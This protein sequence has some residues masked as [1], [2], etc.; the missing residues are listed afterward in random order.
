MRTA[1]ELLEKLGERQVQARDR[2]RTERHARVL[3]RLHGSIERDAPA[4]RGWIAGGAV[5][6]CAA[7]ALALWLSW[8]SPL[9]FEVEARNQ[10]SASSSVVVAEDEPLTVRFSDGSTIVLQPGTQVR[11]GE[12]RVDGVD[13]VLEHGIVDANLEPGGA[14]TL[15][16]GSHTL[17]LR[18]GVSRIE[19]TPEGDR[20][21][22][23]DGPIEM[24][25]LAEPAEIE[26]EAGSVEPL[27]E[28][29]PPEPAVVAPTPRKRTPRVRTAERSEG[30]T[31]SAEPRDDWRALAR[32]GAHREALAEAE[33]AGFSGL[34]ESLGADVLLELA[35]TARYARK[36]AR[37][38]EALSA[39]RRRFPN[40]EAAATAAFD[41]GRL[42]TPN[43]AGCARWF[44]AYLDERPQ[45]SMAD[46]ARQRLEDCETSEPE[47]A[48]R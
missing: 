29:P 10:A 42:A 43:T 17:Q 20:L 22:V 44:R 25:A 6:L 9:T 19:W 40:T 26:V 47:A 46:A 34:C 24:L 15:V 3:E 36:S 32:R 38:R 5:L 41:L 48:A 1:D 13:L 12:Q 30:P 45:G 37:A 4:R 23:A 11:V 31:G 2:G 21:I 28:A 7:A 33:A 18:A 16:A 14:W 39:L 35:D 27:A 8:P